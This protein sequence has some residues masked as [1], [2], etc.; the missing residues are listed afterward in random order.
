[1]NRNKFTLLVLGFFLSFFQAYAQSKLLTMEEAI[2]T[3]KLYPSSLQNVSFLPNG[4]FFCYQIPQSSSPKLY[5]VN[6]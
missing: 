1:M 6:L 5:I 4:N 3:P 2:I